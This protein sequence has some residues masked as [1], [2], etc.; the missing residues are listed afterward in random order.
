[1]SARR[2]A[3]YYGAH[4]L[5]GAL[6]L[7]SVPALR[8]VPLNVPVTYSKDGLMMT[9]YAKIIAEDGFFHAAHVGAPFG[10]DLA[11]WPFGAWLPL[12]AIALLD[13]LL[14]EPGSAINLFWMG[15]ILAAG[16]AATWCLRRLRIRPGLAFVLG[17]LYGF[18]PYA[19]YRNVEHV[20]L[21]FP[22]VPFLALLALRVA[23]LRPGDADRRERVVLGAACVGQGFSYV[24]YT[25]FACL[26]LVAAGA[27]GWIRSRR[28]GPARRAALAIAL[29]TASTA[30]TMAP[31]VAYWR[32]HGRNPYLEYKFARE[33][34]KFGMKL[35]QLVMPITDHPV[36][37]LRDAALAVERA[38]FP[39]ENENVSARLGAVGALG[40]VAIL[41]F[42]LARAGG[43]VPG[44]D[45]DL[46][47]PAGLTLLVLLVST[48]GG[49][50]SLFSVFVSPDI[51]AYNRFVVFL[52]FYC[53][54][55]AGILLQRGVDRWRLPAALSPAVRRLA[56]AALL[57]AGLL[58]EIP[59]LHL[60][61]LRADSD[62][63]FAEDRGLVREIE[64]RLP[65]G[66]MVFQLPHMTI[67]VDR[68]TRLP[69][70]YYDPGRAYVH[71]R[72]LRWSWGSMIGRT[73]GWA[74]RVGAQPAPAMVRA[75]ATAGFDGLWLDR[76]GYTGVQR[77]SFVEVERDLDALVGGKTVSAA[78]RYAFYDLRPQRERLRREIGDAALERERRALLENPPPVPGRWTCVADR[79][80][81]RPGTTP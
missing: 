2:G 36:A 16:L 79:G 29:L 38:G 6:A 53:V 1:M 5:V 45:D 27:A 34:D 26:L 23:G 56:L 24:Y 3:L 33:T 12:G 55:F 40:L 76:W 61:S 32:V 15:T 78:R 14:G 72:S 65:A 69:M 7:A 74:C 22:L 43:L 52:S 64:A 62:A 39:D 10:V 58:D 35:R 73:N 37:A 4:A 11:D 68:N 75:L 8:E 63:R 70:V 30:V 66:A 54:F 48:V 67:P 41:G 49:L 59:M 77:P 81:E 42:A 9:V 57:V 25:F 80:P 60:A 47:A 13:R 20:N 51:R 44:S 71:S 50:A 28:A 46:D 21:T 19:F 31:S 17:T 18:Q